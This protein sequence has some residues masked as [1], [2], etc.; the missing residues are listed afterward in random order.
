M[1]DH[2]FKVELRIRAYKDQI[3]GYYLGWPQRENFVPIVPCI[4]GSN[5]NIDRQRT[6]EL[7]CY[8]TFSDD[9]KERLLSAEPVPPLE[10]VAQYGPP[11]ATPATTEAAKHA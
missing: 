2:Q 11:H 10:W 6:L 4:E 1:N 8:H 5:G 7:P 9:D 3:D